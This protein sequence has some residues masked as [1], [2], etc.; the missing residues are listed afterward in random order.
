VRLFEDL[1]CH[2]KIL[3]Q[4][5]S[6]VSLHQGFRLCV[7]ALCRKRAQHRQRT[8]SFRE[9]AMHHRLLAKCL[10]FSIGFCF[11]FECDI[12]ARSRA[13]LHVEAI[14]NRRLLDQVLSEAVALLP[15]PVSRNRLR[16]QSADHCG[17]LLRLLLVESG[18]LKS[19]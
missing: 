14:E 6:P 7:Q 10:L 3:A 1:Y 18:A 9:T 4:L 15:K 5:G 19:F 13:L 16:R 17:S 2:V 11:D 12:G 8:R